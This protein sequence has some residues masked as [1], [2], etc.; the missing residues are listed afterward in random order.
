[1]ANGFL[2]PSERGVAVD[3]VYRFEKG[4]T[5]GDIK[6]VGDEVLVPVIKSSGDI[7]EV[8][9]PEGAFLFS[10]RVVT[11]AELKALDTSYI[12]LVPKL[13][14][15][16]YYISVDK[17]L[18]QKIGTDVPYTRGSA[19]VHNYVK[20]SVGFNTIN[21]PIAYPT[22]Y[23]EHEHVYVEYLTD[24]LYYTPGAYGAEAASHPI[25]SD[26]PLTLGARFDINF[27]SSSSSYYSARDFDRFILPCRDVSLLIRVIYKYKPSIDLMK[28]MS[29]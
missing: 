24:F 11:N 8:S 29:I 13:N 6:V 14:I 22:W 9:L 10:D 2:I 3:S 16:D 28:E 26:T 20:L 23:A 17:V 21:E 1:M 19:V 25:V 27:R 4:S 18:I 7:S 12:E 15:D 5:A